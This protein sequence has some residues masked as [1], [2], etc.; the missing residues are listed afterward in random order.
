MARLIAI[1]NEKINDS[2]N[3]FAALPRFK[4]SSVRPQAVIHA[5]PKRPFEYHNPPRTNIDNAA[6]AM[7]S[8]FK[9][10]RGIKAPLF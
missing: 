5:F 9:F 1:T 8:Q 6:A 10:A 4:S 3:I 7:A 2:P